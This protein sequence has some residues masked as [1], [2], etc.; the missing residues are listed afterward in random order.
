MMVTYM[1]TDGDSNQLCD[2][3]SEADLKRVARGWANRL[4]VT[5]YAYSNEPHETPG[6]TSAPYPFEPDD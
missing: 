1:I 6:Y 2:G 3:V 5:V 4:G